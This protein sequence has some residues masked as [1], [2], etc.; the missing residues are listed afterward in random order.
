MADTF[1]QPPR[2]GDE[3]EQLEFLLSRMDGLILTN[4][5][6]RWVWS[7]EAT[8]EFFVKSVHQLI[9]DS[10]LPKKEVAKRYH[11]FFS[12]SMTP[13]LWRK[14][15]HWWELKDIDLASYDDWLL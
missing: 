2:G 3:E 15:M 10:I 1:R 8:C 5:P 7:L 11:I 13:H 6:D 14:L 12:C 9:E 4:I